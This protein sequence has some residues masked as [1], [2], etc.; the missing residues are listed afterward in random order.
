MVVVAPVLQGRHGVYDARFFTLVVGLCPHGIPVDQ[1]G[2]LTQ[3]CDTEI[4]QK[5]KTRTSE[6]RYPISLCVDKEQAKQFQ[7]HHRLMYGGSIDNDQFSLKF[8]RACYATFVHNL[9]ID[10]VAEA[11]KRRNTRMEHHKSNRHKL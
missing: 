4:F 3:V 6:P 7:D 11:I 1:V 10:W 5:W 9:E 8:L 2:S